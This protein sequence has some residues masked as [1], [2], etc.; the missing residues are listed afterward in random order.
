[1]AGLFF[2]NY[3]FPIQIAYSLVNDLKQIKQLIYLMHVIL[4]FK[5]AKINLKLAFL[6]K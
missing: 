3:Y 4:T 2:L 6:N 5:G 1:M